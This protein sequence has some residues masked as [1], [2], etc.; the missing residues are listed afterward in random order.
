MADSYAEMDRKLVYSESRITNDWIKC[1]GDMQVKSDCLSTHELKDDHNANDRRRRV[2]PMLGLPLGRI[3]ARNFGHNLPEF[4]SNILI[5]FTG[6]A[7]KRTLSVMAVVMTFTE[8]LLE[9]LFDPR[10]ALLLFAIASARN[11]FFG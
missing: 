7:L 8:L 1:F 11:L 6:F 3:S 10:F 5:E 2:S 9:P 4:V